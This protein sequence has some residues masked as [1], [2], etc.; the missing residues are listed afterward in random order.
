MI[1]E[2]TEKIN[3][4]SE[5]MPFKTHDGLEGLDAHWRDR[6]LLSGYSQK[7]RHNKKGG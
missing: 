3:Q 7:D 1:Y 2:A 6:L 4:R 5:K